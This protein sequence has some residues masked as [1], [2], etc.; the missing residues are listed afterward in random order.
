MPFLVQTIV[1]R[2][3][4]PHGQRWVQTTLWTVGRQSRAPLSTQRAS[5]PFP[6]TFRLSHLC[7]FFIPVN[8]FPSFLH[9]FYLFIPVFIYS[10]IFVE[11]QLHIYRYLFFFLSLI[12]F[13]FI[14]WLFNKYTYSASWGSNLEFSC[15]KILIIVPKMKFIFLGSPQTRTQLLY[16]LN[17]KWLDQRKKKHV[18]HLLCLLTKIQREGFCVVTWRRQQGGCENPIYSGVEEC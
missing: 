16:S 8:H 3:D 18:F 15:S 11:C 12:C 13:P 14:Q 5:P 4:E 6:H 10:S 2:R 1:I 17:P 7:Y 9:L